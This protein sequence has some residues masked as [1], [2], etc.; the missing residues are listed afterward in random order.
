M[1][2]KVC[3][4]GPGFAVQGGI[5]SVLVSYKKLFNLSKTNFISSYNGSFL[6]SIPLLLKTCF[7]ILF[8]KNHNFEIF[9]IHTSTYGSFFRKFI[10]S[11]CLRVKKEK[12]V[13]HIHGSI[14][15][16]FCSSSP[17]LIQFF[18]RSYLK[19]AEVIICITPD[20]QEFLDNFIGK[21]T[22]K[23]SIIPNP[24]EN[25]A[26]NPIDLAQHTLPVKIVFSG[27]Y[28]KRKGVYDLIEAF[29][30]TDFDFP[31]ELYL[32]G[33]GETEKVRQTVATKSKANL[34]HVSDWL[35]HKEYLDNLIQYDI[36]ALPSYAE[37]FG[38]SLVEAMGNGIPVISTFS[39]G[40]P[41]VVENNTTGFL[42]APGDIEAL[43]KSIKKLVNN[44]DL[45]IAM[46]KSA[47]EYTK[48][49]FS[50]TVILKKLNS[51]YRELL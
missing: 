36:L 40:V 4:I 27:R 37:T 16:K 8:K 13:A 39:G 3:H 10:I 38:M 34:I 26:E 21:D 14:F 12:Y 41:Y 50:G 47:W 45:R 9:Q 49:H 18:I 42:N 22:C 32:F 33:D 2:E 28:G 17:K 11:L 29:D 43:S 25:I 1:L 6:K 24:C 23:F 35:T 5:S 46:G 15:K 48:S 19:K 20:M 31:T 30:K 44:K 7:K 51:L